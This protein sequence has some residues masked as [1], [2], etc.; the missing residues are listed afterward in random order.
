MWKTILGILGSG[1]GEPFN[2]LYRGE[3]L[4]R[5]GGTRR[6]PNYGYPTAILKREPPTR[7]K[8][9]IGSSSLPFLSSRPPIWGFEGRGDYGARLS[10]RRANS[11]TVDLR[12]ELSAKIE[13]KNLFQ[14]LRESGTDQ[15]REFPGRK[16]TKYLAISSLKKVSA[17]RFTGIEIRFRFPSAFTRKSNSGTCT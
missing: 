2:R 9:V 14:A 5:R 13:K 8:V 7:D 1:I 17:W 12:Q 4:W 11:I 3:F 10:K 6:G 16:W 15:P